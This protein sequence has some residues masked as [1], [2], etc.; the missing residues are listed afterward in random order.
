MYVM[1]ATRVRSIAPGAGICVHLP[2]ACMSV[3]VLRIM[4]CRCAL[5]CAMLG[6]V[7]W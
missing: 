3:F 7:E 2:Q 4:R 6:M 1:N 5:W